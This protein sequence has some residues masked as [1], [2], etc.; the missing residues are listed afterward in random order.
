MS[1]YP[2]GGSP[3]LVRALSMTVRADN[4]TLSHLITNGLHGVEP[5]SGGREVE[6]L[7]TSDMIEVHD[8]VGVGGRAVSA[9]LALRS[10]QVVLNLLLVP[11]RVLAA[12]LSTVVRGPEPGHRLVMLGLPR[13]VSAEFGPI[14]TASLEAQVASAPSD[15]VTMPTMPLFE[16][17]VRPNF[18]TFAWHGKG[19]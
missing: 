1:N 6:Q 18:A 2:P 13:R 12:L 3:P 17:T 19:E 16:R 14:L 7:L 10:V 15:I 4:V 8:V 5:A 9:R 11:S